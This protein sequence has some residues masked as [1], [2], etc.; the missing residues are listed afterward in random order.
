MA[1]ASETL[2]WRVV[3]GA[4][5][6]WGPDRRL[7][8]VQ[9]GLAIAE[10]LPVEVAPRWQGMLERWRAAHAPVAHGDG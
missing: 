8:D 1:A 3:F 4:P 2:R 5:L 10:L 7:R 9:L 6:D